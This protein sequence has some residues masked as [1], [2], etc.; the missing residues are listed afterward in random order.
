LR[1]G[2]AL[3]KYP[4]DTGESRNKTDYLTSN[5]RESAFTVV[6]TWASSYEEYSQKCRKMVESYGWTLL[7]VEKLMLPVMTLLVAKK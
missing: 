1:F 3:S 5:G 2:L 6:T 7:Q 4:A